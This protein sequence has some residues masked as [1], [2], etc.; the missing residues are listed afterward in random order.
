MYVRYMRNIYMQYVE[1]SN[2]DVGN[3]AGRGPA[4]FLLSSQTA[5]FQPAPPMPAARARYHLCKQ[6][7]RSACLS[8][9]GLKR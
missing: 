3:A 2:K 1:E 5:G 8:V 7:Q 4:T 9:A 6:F